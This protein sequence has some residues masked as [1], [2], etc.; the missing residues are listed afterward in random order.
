MRQNHYTLTPALVRL[1]AQDL[2]QRHLRLADHG[3]K[4]TAA[5]L[6]TLLFYAATEAFTAEPKLAADV[7]TAH[8]YR[9][10]Q[11][12]ALAGCG[13]GR[14]AAGLSAAERARLRGQALEWLRADL[15]LWTRQR[16]AGSPQDRQAVTARMQEWLREPSL[17]GVRDARGLAGLPA[18]ERRLWQAFWDDVAAA[19]T[20]DLKGQEPPPSQPARRP[21]K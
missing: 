6:W 20:R 16:A 1:H 4:C 13:Q 9:A 15:A 10:A 3:R 19:Q 8:R 17:A 14:D 7:Q 11:S 21:E 2:C 18:E 5:M 12:A